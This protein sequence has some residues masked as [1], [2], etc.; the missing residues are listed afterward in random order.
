M[1]DHRTPEATVLDNAAAMRTDQQKLSKAHVKLLLKRLGAEVV[2]AEEKY[3]KALARSK[4]AIKRSWTC[5]DDVRRLERRI[6]K[7][8]AQAQS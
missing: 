1:T 5:E 4:R 6:A 7:I 8:Q 3:R 2:R